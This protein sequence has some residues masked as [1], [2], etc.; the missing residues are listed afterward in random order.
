[1]VMEEVISSIEQFG[2]G[3]Q[4]VF[5]PYSFTAHGKHSPEQQA[6]A[7]YVEINATYGRV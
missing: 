3:N 2:G 4:R 5:E 7:Q 1:M 6:A